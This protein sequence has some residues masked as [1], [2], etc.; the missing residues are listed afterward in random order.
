[1]AMAAFTS[2]IGAGK[3]M[4]GACQA[5]AES[6]HTQGLKL[7]TTDQNPG[8]CQFCEH[9]GFSLQGMD[10]MALALTEP[11]RT[12]PLAQRSCELIF[13]KQSKKG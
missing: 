1:M 7:I 3:A 6:H 13:Y 10:R 4:L 5:W 2:V 11:E 9:E 12:K 8:M